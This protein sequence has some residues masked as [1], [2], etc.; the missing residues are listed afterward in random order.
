MVFQDDPAS[1]WGPAYVQG[2]LWVVGTV[3]DMHQCF[4]GLQISYLSLFNLLFVCATSAWPL[5][6]TS[7]GKKSSQCVVEV[8]SWSQISHGDHHEGTVFF[9][10]RGTPCCLIL[11]LQAFLEA[12]TLGLAWFKSTSSCVDFCQK[13]ERFGWFR[14]F[15]LN[16]SN[17]PARGLGWSLHRNI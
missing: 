4:Q 5:C 16:S 10:K 3:D 17:W 7:F 8:R 1:S 11:P 2:W 12:T 15:L 9:L 14:V 13:G 6:W